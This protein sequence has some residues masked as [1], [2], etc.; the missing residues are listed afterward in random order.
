MRTDVSPQIVLDREI[1]P[2]AA[3]LLAGATVS[4]ADAPIDEQ[5]RNAVRL[6]ERW[7]VGEKSWGT[8]DPFPRALM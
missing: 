8:V 6:R 3:A 1:A 4:S 7:V 5:R 2:F